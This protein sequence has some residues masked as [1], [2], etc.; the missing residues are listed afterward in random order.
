MI[1][2]VSPR[3]YKVCKEDE[4]DRCFSKKSLPKK[5]AVKQRIAIIISETQRRSKA[6]PKPKK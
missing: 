2:Q 1:K 3:G 5:T 4:P 6:T